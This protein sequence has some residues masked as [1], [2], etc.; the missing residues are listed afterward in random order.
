MLIEA[1]FHRWPIHPISALQWDAI[2]SYGEC[3]SARVVSKAT[4]TSCL[5][6]WDNVVQNE[7]DK[8]RRCFRQ[9]ALPLLEA[10]NLINRCH[11]C[12]L[13]YLADPTPAPMPPPAIPETVG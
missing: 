10:F 8:I 5:E 9:L 12:Y 11:P 6:Q 2:G 13:A 3:A 7:T 1:K 4:E